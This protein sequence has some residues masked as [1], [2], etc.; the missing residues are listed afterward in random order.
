MSTDA[1]LRTMTVALLD[2]NGVPYCGLHEPVSSMHDDEKDP[3]FCTCETCGKRYFTPQHVLNGVIIANVEV[4]LTMLQ[5][6]LKRIGP[7]EAAKTLEDIAERFG[8]RR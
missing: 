5:L 3:R 2:A 6:G 7:E 1:D 8:L 4:C